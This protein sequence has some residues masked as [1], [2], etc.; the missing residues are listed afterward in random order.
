MRKVAKL[1]GK[2]LHSSRQ[3]SS[4]KRK[5]FKQGGGEV[6]TGLRMKANELCL[7]VQKRQSNARARMNLGASVKNWGE[8]KLRRRGRIKTS[9]RHN[10][11]LPVAS[12]G[13]LIAL[14]HNP[15][16]VVSENIVADHA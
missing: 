13:G 4:Q 8:W 5:L 2:I 11:L 15:V 12:T 14:L 7:T 3:N 10:P 1:G 9:R 6:D 16:G